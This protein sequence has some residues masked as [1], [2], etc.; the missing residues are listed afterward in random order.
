MPLIDPTLIPSRVL[1]LKHVDEL[2]ALYDRLEMR[3]VEKIV[4]P[5]KPSG[6]RPSNL[7]RVYCQSHLRRCLVLARSAYGLFFIENGLVSLMAVRA[8]YETVAVFCAFE[9]QF[10]QLAKTGTIQAIHDFP[11]NKAYATR[12]KKMI[13]KHGAQVTATNIQ[14]DVAKLKPVRTKVEEEYDFLSEHT[15]PAGFGTILYFAEKLKTE[16]TYVFHDGGPEP[17]AD[18]QWIMV[19]IK[20][21]EGFEKALDRAARF[22]PM[23]LNGARA[24]GAAASGI[25]SR[26]RGTVV[27]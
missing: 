25:A 5:E 12:S 23:D 10:L 1:S 4:I 26:V 9:Q 20:L 8:I 13:E 2:N 18:L 6:F 21:L 16:D 19:G 17:E 15:H 14:T 11:Q 3:K 24:V 7:V 27:T 22:V